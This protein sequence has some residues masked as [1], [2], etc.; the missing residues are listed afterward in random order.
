MFIPKNTDLGI[1]DF[2]MLLKKILKKEIK[3]KEYLVWGLV[4]YNH[5][6]YIN[7]VFLLLTFVMLAPEMYAYA[8]RV[9][10]NQTALREE[11][12]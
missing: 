4:I 2:I 10:L 11:S 1:H 12:D 3:R 9:N 5:N 7:Y 8:N 6:T